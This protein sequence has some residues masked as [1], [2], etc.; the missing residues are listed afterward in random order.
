VV[1]VLVLVLVTVEV[2]PR[3]V[4]TEVTVE[5]GPRAVETEVMVSVEAVVVDSAAADGPEKV[6]WVLP[7]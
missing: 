1:N 4:E 2:G 5:V 3:A 6:N 7:E